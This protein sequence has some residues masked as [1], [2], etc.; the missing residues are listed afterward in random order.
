MNSW[1]KYEYTFCLI[2][3]DSLTTHSFLRIIY[4]FKANKDFW[5]L[6]LS[7]STNVF[8]VTDK[9]FILYYQKAQKDKISSSVSGWNLCEKNNNHSNETSQVYTFGIFAIF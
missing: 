4:K 9:N 5:L 1:C 7:F 3:S 6:P 2:A 8:F